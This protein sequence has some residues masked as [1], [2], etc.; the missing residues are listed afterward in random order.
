MS[1]TATRQAVL[2]MWVCARSRPLSCRTDEVVRVHHG[3]L[4]QQR[5]DVG[6]IPAGGRQLALRVRESTTTSGR[7]VRFDIRLG[8]PAVSS[9]E[10][11]AAT[12][13]SAAD[14]AEQL[15]HG[16]LSMVERLLSLRAVVRLEQSARALQ[17]ALHRD[18]NQREAGH[19]WGEQQPT[20]RHQS[21]ARGRSERTDGRRVGQPRLTRSEAILTARQLRISVRDT[22]RSATQMKMV[23]GDKILYII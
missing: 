8:P 22:G 3:D 20:A 17:Q 2:W 14:L 15:L 21:G 12:A 13:A 9:S 23:R 1:T 7:A 5:F 18:A 16:L 6:L 19:R 10:H 11:P 4:A